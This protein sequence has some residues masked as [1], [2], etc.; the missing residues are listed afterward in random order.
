MLSVELYL[1][2]VFK[3]HKLIFHKLEVFTIVK[4]VANVTD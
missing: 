3:L 4:L 2:A 1:N